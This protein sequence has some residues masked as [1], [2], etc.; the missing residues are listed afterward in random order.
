MEINIEL[1]DKVTCKVNGE[2]DEYFISSNPKK[3][4]TIINMGCIG[5]KYIIE[6]KIKS[7][8]KKQK[9]IL[10]KDNELKISI[11][12]EE[13]N[14]ELFKKNN[15][16]EYLTNKCHKHHH[17]IND[18][19]SRNSK[20][21]EEVENNNKNNLS[22]AYEMNNQRITYLNN[23]INS[24]ESKYELKRI[25][26][27]Q[28]WNKQL[29]KEKEEKK[30]FKTQ[31]E[32]IL[33]CLD[34]FQTNASS[35]K[36]KLG[37]KQIEEYLKANF[38]NYTLENTSKA[39]HQGD[40]FMY[41]S[42]NKKIMLEIKN[43]DS[44]NI[45]NSQID[46]FYKDIDYCNDNNKN[47]NG[48]VFISLHTDIYGKSIL[49]FEEYKNIPIIYVSKLSDDINRLMLSLKL[50]NKLILLKNEYGEHN[51]QFY[52]FNYINNK[53]NVMNQVIES[54]DSQKKVMEEIVQYVK[55]KQTKYNRDYKK[56]MDYIHQIL[57]E[58]S[59]KIKNNTIALDTDGYNFL[60]I[61]DPK[62]I[63]HNMLIKYQK[64]YLNILHNSSVNDTRFNCINQIENMSSDSIPR[65]SYSN[66]H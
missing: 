60:E 40:Y 42:E 30:M 66:E 7:S 63:S 41:M 4:N 32:E 33:K 3:R 51:N 58:I 43:Y 1:K 53:I 62:D 15:E 16:I 59:D 11:I 5:L 14:K 28:Y 49:D 57:D 37:E 31:Y 39:G 6:H 9:E 38:K 29:D 21:L 46:K 64:S 25:E 20:T 44:E 47:I 23:I 48:A 50:L 55:Q 34:I 45:R 61:T 13:H 12:N 36:G 56:Y 65:S 22:K 26:Q 18:I 19:Y 17:E 10:Q 8:N 2:I 35:N 52:L 27:E 54:F 24:Q